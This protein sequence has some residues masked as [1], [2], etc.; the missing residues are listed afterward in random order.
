CLGRRVASHRIRAGTV[1]LSARHVEGSGGGTSL[2]A[3]RSCPLACEPRRRRRAHPLVVGA[4]RSGLVQ[5]L[6]DD[7]FE[8]LRARKKLEMCARRLQELIEGLHFVK[9]VAEFVEDE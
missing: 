2:R 1:E 9:T 7:L 5:A 3:R 6:E 4:P 8:V